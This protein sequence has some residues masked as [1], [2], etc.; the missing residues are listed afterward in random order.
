MN[1]DA[2]TARRGRKA[3]LAVLA[4]VAV[5]A[6]ALTGCSSTPLGAGGGS[7]AAGETAVVGLAGSFLTNPFQVVLVDGIGTDAESIGLDLLPAT[8][9]DADPAQQITDIQNLLSQNVNGLIVIPVDSD[10]VV[11]GIEQANSQNVPV[12]TVDVAPNGGDVY[13]VV[14]ADNYYMG[15]A[16]CESMGEAIGGA[17]TV[18]NLQGDLASV[19]GLDRSDGFTDCMTEQFPDVEVIS[20]PTNWVAQEAADAAQAVAS[21]TDL[22]GIFMA[23]DTVMGP[24]IAQVLQTQNKWTKSDAPDHIYLAAIDG[25]SDALQFVRDGYFDAVVSQPADLYSQYATQYIKDAIDG[26]TYEEGPTDHDSE[27]VADENGILEDLLPSPVVTLENVDDPAL[28]G[29]SQG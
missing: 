6:L 1:V 21:T 11:P 16:A 26:K 20:R 4:G 24:S 10:A 18:L 14:R 28:W 19:N 25:G 5:P 2:R 29:N 8:N 12:V 7:P 23:S 22:A 13:M 15:K 27:I 17:G 3:A 9:A